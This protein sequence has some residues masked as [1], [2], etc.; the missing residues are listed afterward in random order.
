MNK[1]LQKEIGTQLKKIYK[2]EMKLD[3]LPKMDGQVAYWA[4]FAVINAIVEHCK[5]TLAK[6]ETYP[7]KQQDRLLKEDFIKVAQ[8]DLREARA[9]KRVLE[10]HLYR[11]GG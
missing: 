3:A 10:R 4:A 1:D 5:K 7:V 6:T 2:S 8:H 9:A 11:I